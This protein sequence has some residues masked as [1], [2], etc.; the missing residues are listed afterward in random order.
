MPGPADS[1]RR[2]FLR[3]AIATMLGSMA[4]L[5]AAVLTAF[6]IPRRAGAPPV[7]TRVAPLDRLPADRYRSVRIRVR[8]RQG[9]LERQVERVVY[10]RREGDD[11]RVLS[12][13]CTHLGCSVRWVN[14]AAE[15]RCPCH[16]GVYDLE[17]RVR[18]GPPP[19]PLHRFEAR[20][21]EGVVEILHG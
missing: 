8:E 14:A 17:G 6:S 4:A 2:S 16:G 21:R 3:T 19:R 18:A 15:F 10:A 20:T 1:S 11:A 5:M 13:I 7:W 9:W 12:P